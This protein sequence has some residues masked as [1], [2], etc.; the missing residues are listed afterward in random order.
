MRTIFALTALI[1]TSLA[2]DSFSQ[3]P[4]RTDFYAQP[5]AGHSF[6]KTEYVMDIKTIDGDG[7]PYRLKSQLEYPLDVLMVGTNVGLTLTPPSGKAWRVELGAF[8][9]V[10]DPGGTM[11]DH[12]WVAVDNEPLQKFSYTESDAE[13]N[14][15]LL[16]LEVGKT[17]WLDERRQ[18]ELMAGFR[19]HRIEQDIIGYE[20]WQLDGNGDR[21]D[22]ADKTSEALFY[23]VTYSLPHAGLRGGLRL[24]RMVHVDGKAAFA[25]VLVSDYDNHLLRNKDAE[26]R[27]TGHGFIGGAGLRHDLGSTP[28]RGLFFGLDA[29]I[30]YL[31]ASGRQTQTWYGDDGATEWDDTG[32]EIGGIPHEINTTQYHVGLVFGWRF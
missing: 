20:G 3:S 31:T 21:V 1:M 29:D 30:L 32:T 22:V 19:W 23:R 27:I 7:N 5:Y 18:I 8:T 4:L 6:G 14:S 12:D 24:G 10:T 13:M 28:G 16:T 2:A 15:I 11:Y 9:S 17:V 26:A 25:I